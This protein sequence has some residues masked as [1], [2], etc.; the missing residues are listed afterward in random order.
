MA[1]DNELGVVPVDQMVGGDGDTPGLSQPVTLDEVQDIV[2]SEHPREERIARLRGLRDDL[3]QRMSGDMGGEFDA[4]VAEIDGAIA[5]L[6]GPGDIVGTR[7]ALGLAADARAGS[8]PAL[9][10]E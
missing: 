3:A 1:E 8:D 9:K 7:D 10:P 4:L 6:E 5:T 2:M